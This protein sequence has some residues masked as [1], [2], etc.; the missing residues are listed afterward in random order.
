MLL[1][2]ITSVDIQLNLLRVLILNKIDYLYYP[3][4]TIVYVEG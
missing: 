3:E 4:C 2:K 1:S